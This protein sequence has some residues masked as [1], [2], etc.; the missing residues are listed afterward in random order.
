MFLHRT[1]SIFNILGKIIFSNINK[2][3]KNSFSFVLSWILLLIT[4]TLSLV[5][6]IDFLLNIFVGVL[7]DMTMPA[8]SSVC[9]LSSS[10][11]RVFQYISNIV[12]TME[13]I[14]NDYVDQQLDETEQYTVSETSV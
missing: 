7:R 8:P 4:F 1:Y 9:T 12:S 6:F 13:P 11:N 14:S 3:D 10:Q 5:L 2:K